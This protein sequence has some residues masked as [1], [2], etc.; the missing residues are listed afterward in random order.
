M[1]RL[2]ATDQVVKAT[3]KANS[4]MEVLALAEAQGIPLADDTAARCVKV[5]REVV[6]ENTKVDVLIV[7]RQ[8]EV[9]SHAG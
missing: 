3:R 5:A 8:G 9:V 1:Q 2:G 6:H 4:A 7:D